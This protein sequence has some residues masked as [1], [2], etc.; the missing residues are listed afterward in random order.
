MVVVEDFGCTWLAITVMGSEQVNG[1]VKEN[2]IFKLPKANF[3]ISIYYI[4][5]AKLQKSSSASC[6]LQSTF[7]RLSI[8]SSIKLRKCHWMWPDA[9]A[10]KV[11]CYILC[12]FLW[13]LMCFKF[14]NRLIEFFLTHNTLVSLSQHLILLQTSFQQSHAAIINNMWADVSA[15]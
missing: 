4:F 9:S 14:A 13:L 15:Q 6:L 8:W 2:G 12:Y 7:Q 10:A 5:F 3:Q 11:A 1:V